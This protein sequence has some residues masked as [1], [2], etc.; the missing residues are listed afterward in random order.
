MSRLYYKPRKKAYDVAMTVEYVPFPSEQ[1][2]KEAYDT[3]AKLYLKAKERMLKNMTQ[4][5]KKRRELSDVVDN[6]GRL[7]PPRVSH[8]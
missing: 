1:A 2:R 5:R 7:A 4:K 8:N 6:A 3:Q